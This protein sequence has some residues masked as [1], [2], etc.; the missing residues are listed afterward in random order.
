[1]P[2]QKKIYTSDDGRIYINKHLPVYLWMSSSPDENA[3]KYRLIS[4]DS[5]EYTNPLYFDTEGYNTVRTPS[6]VD[7]LTKRAIFPLD[8]IIFEVYADGLPPVVKHKFKGTRPFFNRSKAIIKGD[9]TIE[10]NAYDAVSGVEK[11][12]FSL[13]GEPFK[14]Y[15]EP[16]ALTSAGD[17]TLRYYSVDK[18]GNAQTTKVVEFSVDQ[19]PP[20]SS[21]IIEGDSS[22]EVISGRSK[23][24]ISAEDEYAGLKSIKYKIDNGKEQIYKYKLFAKYLT[25][26]EHTITY[27]AEDNVGNIEDRQIKNIY[28]DK[29]APMIIDEIQGDSYIIGGKEYLSGRAKMKLT[30][31]DNKAGVKNIFYST[32]GVDFEEYKEPFY[33]PSQT[34]N[35]KIVFYA[36]DNVNNKSA[37]SG[38]ASSANRNSYMDLTGPTVKYKF[39]GKTFSNHDTI[40]LSPETK[41]VLAAWDSESGVQK[42]MYKINNEQE[43]EYRDPIQ[44]QSAGKSTIQFTGYDNVNNT[45]SKSFD[46]FVD[47]QGPEVFHRFSTPAISQG[48]I[49][50]YPW[51]VALFLSATD[52]TGF[53][54]ITYSLNQNS[55]QKYSGYIQGLQKNEEYNL[56]VKA[57]DKIGNISEDVINFKTSD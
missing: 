31:L 41:I 17:Y 37:S 45:N 40:Y 48:T 11:V 32:N 3:P 14:E 42:I 5:K 27:Y 7:T 44:V 38:A 56:R 24:V 10:L 26:G 9:A 1:M 22:G 16:I 47:N 18:V 46:V 28:I 49:P 43:Q 39:S 6:K 36:V 53:E 30:A 23:I 29:S 51:H 21:F 20:K 12:Y 4:E 34:G 8:D 50:I 57:F 13:N 52:A 2:H 19:K 33:M 25:E 54:K 35:M 55:E 15:N